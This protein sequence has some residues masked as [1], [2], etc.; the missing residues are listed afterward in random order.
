MLI[1]SYFFTI[2]G[3]CSEYLPWFFE[4][5]QNKTLQYVLSYDCPETDIPCICET[6]EHPR[7]HAATQSLL[8]RQT[9]E[10][11]RIS[12]KD[13]LKVGA[14]R[15]ES[16]KICKS[17]ESC[18][19]TKADAFTCQSVKLTPEGIRFFPSHG[20]LLYTNTPWQD[21]VP[22]MYYPMKKLFLLALFERMVGSSSS[23]HP[24]HFHA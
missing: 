22:E 11:N 3:F 10:L 21:I 17:K 2:A 6:P 19:Q 13:L 9:K 20:R 7:Q 4:N 14:E 8:Y 16:G 12:R 18:V 1:L 23:P 5:Y 24:V 15:S